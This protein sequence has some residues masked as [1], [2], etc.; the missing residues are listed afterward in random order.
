MLDCRPDEDNVYQTMDTSAFHSR[1]HH[2]SSQSLQKSSDVACPFLVAF[3]TLVPT[4]T[5]SVA[6]VHHGFVQA[7]RAR[8]I[9][10][11]RRR[12]GTRVHP[13][14]PARPVGAAVRWQ[15]RSR[16]TRHHAVQ[17]PPVGP[18]S[19]LRPDGII[20]EGNS[21]RWSGWFRQ[22]ER[23]EPVFSSRSGEAVLSERPV[24]GALISDD[25]NCWWVPQSG[26]HLR[27]RCDA[28]EQ[29]TV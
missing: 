9:A 5:I 22:C 26:K 2:L 14:F 1:T 13:R 6:E 12:L 4:N 8:T 16:H 25:R 10:A 21:D 23:P 11:S 17:R 3:A 18:R 15:P 7:A 27:H 28:K 29:A 20:S 24:E 19:Y